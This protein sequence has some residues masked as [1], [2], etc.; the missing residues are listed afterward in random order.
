[1]L[2]S[3]KLLL[4]VIFTLLFSSIASFA[5]G[6]LSDLEKQLEENE[7]NKKNAEQEKKKIEN[8]I[9]NAE[10]KLEELDLEVNKV[11]LD[12][13]IVNSEIIK[14]TNDIN[15]TTKELEEAQNNIDD[16]KDLLDSRIRAMYKNKSFSYIEV[17]LSSRS[18]SDFFSRLEVLKRIIKQ[19]KELLKFM[20]NQKDIVENK[21][22]ELDELKISFLNEQSKVE[23]KKKELE[24]ASR[25]AQQERDTLK[26][27]KRKLEKSIDDLNKQAKELDKKIREL[28]GSGKYSGKMIWPVPRY[29]R[30]SSYFG[31][32]KHP[33][34]G[35]TKLHTGID[36]PAPLGTSVKAASDGKVIYSGW[37]GGY[38][39]VVMIDHGDKIV[40]LY[41]H[42]SSLL[43]SAGQTVDEG[44]T[45]SRMG[46]TGYS[47]GSHL[48]FEV[49]VNGV[50]KNPLDGWVKK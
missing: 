35:Y 1:M 28:Q 10:S 44:D 3:R 34:F 14:L 9:K 15:N 37:L 38:G 22:K 50:Y 36:I 21:K 49:R 2:K 16:K 4:L 41:A 6:D 7:N 32:R 13:E 25:S 47:T 29:Y 40:T 26:N 33:I 18:I 39:K 5:D 24:V 11:E 42:N 48:H 43:V 30:I 19:D 31:M 27:D 45:I 20:N 17:I 46:S 12:L 8:N 23:S